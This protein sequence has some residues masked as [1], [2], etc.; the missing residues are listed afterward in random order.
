MIHHRTLFALGALLVPIVAL[1]TE[2]SGCSSTSTTSPPQDTGTGTG[3]STGTHTEV[4]SGSKKKDSGTEKD[5]GP[6]VASE[7]AGDAESDD[8]G[9][10]ESEDAGDAESDVTSDVVSDAKSDAKSDAGCVDISVVNYKGWCNIEV[11]GMTISGAPPTTTD[12]PVCVAA[13]ATL[14]AQASPKPAAGF[15]E[16]GPDPWLSGATQTSVKDA[17]PDGAVTSSATLK[18]G[19]TCVVACCPFGADATGHDA[20]SGCSGLPTTCSS[21]LDGGM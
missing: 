13:G 16:L 2:G 20:G 11:G 1:V 10:G 8:A 19:S 7:D 18:A 15:F 4:D 9:D 3:T 5:T 14:T 17:G 6:D 12:T 21:Y